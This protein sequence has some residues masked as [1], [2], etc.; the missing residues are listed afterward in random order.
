MTQRLKAAALSGHAGAQIA[1]CGAGAI[2]A[3]VGVWWNGDQKFYEGQV[4]FFNPTTTEH[5]VAYDD[6]EVGVHR[7]WQHD[8]RIRLLNAPSE[9]GQHAHEARLKIKESAFEKSVQRMQPEVF[10]KVTEAI[11]AAHT[12]TPEV[13]KAMAGIDGVLREHLILQKSLVDSNANGSGG[14]DTMVP[15][16]LVPLNLL[17]SGMPTSFTPHVTGHGIECGTITRGRAVTIDRGKGRP[18]G[19]VGGVLKSQKMKKQR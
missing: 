15:L 7:L 16:N 6:G 18:T 1:A 3:K 10:S 8:E 14:V 11:E 12:M 5:V 2:G 19:S 4:C 9:W 17:P 13:E